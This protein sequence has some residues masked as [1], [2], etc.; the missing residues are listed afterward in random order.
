HPPLLDTG[1]RLA[2]QMRQLTSRT[3]LIGDNGAFHV[4]VAIERVRNSRQ[5]PHVEVS[6]SGVRRR[7]LI[8]LKPT[9]LDFASLRVH[10][11]P[12]SQF[13]RMATQATATLKAEIHFEPAPADDASDLLAALEAMAGGREAI[14][15][16]RSQI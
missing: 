5:Q 7:L 2:V 10:D 4:G 15:A 11:M 13:V 3:P 6:L 1:P 8:L 14:D 12:H 16:V 9:T